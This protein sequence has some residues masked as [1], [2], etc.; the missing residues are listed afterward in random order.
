MWV[1]H[2]EESRQGTCC[3][4]KRNKLLFHLIQLFQHLYCSLLYKVVEII[5]FLH[6]YNR[7]SFI[8]QKSPLYS[9]KNKVQ[10]MWCKLFGLIGNLFNLFKS[11]QLHIFSYLIMTFN[12]HVYCILS[13]DAKVKIYVTKV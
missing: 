3:R 5:L 2:S 6:A 10:C 4:R 8:F 1:L 11:D 13:S 7:K 12:L 9:L